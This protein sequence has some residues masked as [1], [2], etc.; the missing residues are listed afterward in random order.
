MKTLFDGTLK[1]VL[2]DKKIS[3]TLRQISVAGLS[4]EE[5]VI[6]LHDP[7][8]IRKAY[9]EKLENQGVVRDLEGKLVSSYTVCV[10]GDGKQL[11]LSDIT[12]YSNGDKAHY[13]QQAE[14]AKVVNKQVA[15]I[16][17]KEEVAF[18][19]REQAILQLL[20]DDELV[21]LGRVSRKQLQAVSSQF[22]AANPE[23]ERYGMC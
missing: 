17:A 16:K 3:E 21:N 23:V 20:A 18:T 5:V 15:G 7:C 22:K 1:S 6:A 11:H 19:E 13:V 10:S 12:V 14:L 9:S 4:D 2:D 8:D